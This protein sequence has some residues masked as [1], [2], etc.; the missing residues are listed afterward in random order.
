M[1]NLNNRNP[2][3][4]KDRVKTEFL[5]MKVGSIYEKARVMSTQ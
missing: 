2:L 3:L 4:M 5:G 1:S